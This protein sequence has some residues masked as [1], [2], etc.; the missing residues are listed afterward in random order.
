VARGAKDAAFVIQ[1]L[2]GLVI[3]HRRQIHLKIGIPRALTY[4]LYHDLWEGFF[5]RLNVETIVSPPTNRLIAKYGTADAIDEAC[6]SSKVYLG[7]VRYL[8]DKCDMVFVPR[9]EST[10]IREELCTRLFGIYDL[11]RHTFPGTPLLHADIN[12]LLRKRESAAFTEIGLA[13]GKTKEEAQEA[14][15]YALERAEHIKAEA[16]QKQEELLAAPGAKVLI[17]AH[18]YNTHDEYIG[19][20][21]LDYFTKNGVKTAFADVIGVREARLKA[22]ETFGNR[23][24]WRVNMEIIGG[25]LKY[26]DAVDGV[27]LISTFPCGP[28]AI[29]NELVMRAVKD[30]PV[31]TLIIDELSADAGLA[32]RLESFT[33]VIT[34]NRRLKQHA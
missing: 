2:T 32:T 10:G 15:Q 21:V 23:M 24:Y 13:L 25:V 3:N 33:D 5:E 34:A 11:V 6:Y 27:V 20:P 18:A 1:Y 31:L 9:I 12:F 19:K 26:Q 28:D 16:V 29:S 14:Y 17:A 30:K 7:H 22:Q 4:H 8:L